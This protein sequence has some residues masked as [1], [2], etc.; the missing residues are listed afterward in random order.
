MAIF[1]VACGVKKTA[2]IASPTG[3]TLI[4]ID[5]VSVVPSINGT[6]TTSMVYVHNNSNVTINEISYSAQ[7]NL[8]NQKPFLSAASVEACRS[9]LAGKSCALIFTT[10]EINSLKTQGSTVLSASYTVNNYNNNQPNSFSQV[11]NYRRVSN[12]N[13][14][15]VKFNSGLLLSSAGNPTAYGMLYL[16]S[17]GGGHSYIL[18]NLRSNESKINITQ[19]SFNNQVLSQNSVYAVEVSAD[20]N[21][22]VNNSSESVDNDAEKN[23]VG[24]KELSGGFYANLT[25]TSS[26]TNSVPFISVANLSIKPENSGAVLIAGL[27]PITDL[28]IG[29]RT[30]LM[31]IVNTGSA[32]ASIGDI[33]FPTGLTRSGGANDCIATLAAGASCVVYFRL[34]PDGGNG[35]ITIPYDDSKL[36]QS[37][38]WYGSSS[39]PFL[40]MSTSADT[41]SFASTIGGSAL[42]TVT[43]IGSS[44]LSNVVTSAATISGN[45]IVNTTK[46]ICKDESNSSTGTTLEVGGS[47]S[48]QIT[49]VDNKLEAGKINLSFSGS[50]ATG[51]S[52]IY[53]QIL[54]MD[55]NSMLHST[56]LSSGESN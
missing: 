20:V 16:Y 36:T 43:N 35:N 39:D 32:L 45:A 24:N 6:P 47:C 29:N 13:F 28:S 34:P 19:E 42:V 22:V 44:R 37:I 11:I 5:S 38:T 14:D 27:V 2:T 12:S 48:Y 25:A 52:A 3:V 17:S 9:I 23:L 55:Y 18:N 10:P 40:A 51:T 41:L 54:A 1:V 50:F 46:L 49:V 4:T 33:I 7:S 21:D 53:N 26:S 15:G 30:G 31:Y 56:L 8:R